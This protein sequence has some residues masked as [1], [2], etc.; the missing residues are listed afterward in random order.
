[1]TVFELLLGS[2][3]N[4]VFDDGRQPEVD[5]LHHSGVVS[6]K[7]SGKSSLKEKETQQYK[8]VSRSRHIKREKASLPVDVRRS[9]TSLLKVPLESSSAT[10]REIYR[11]SHCR[12]RTFRILIFL[13][14]HYS[15][16]DPPKLP[17]I[18]NIK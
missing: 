18:R 14:Y 13:P 16:T 1:M 6:L 15:S 9:K 5:F 17:K 2:L 3:S 8:F 11:N 12:T 10:K 7:L 4:S